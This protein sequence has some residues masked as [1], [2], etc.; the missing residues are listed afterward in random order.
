V[1][2]SRGRPT[3]CTAEL[4]EQI[5][6]IVRAG[7]YL[8][9]ACAL[10]G[11]VYVTAQS[12]LERGATETERRAAGLTA[13]Q[14]REHDLPSA[15]SQQPYV[16]FLGAITRARAEAESRH[17]RNVERIAMGGQVTELREEVAPDGTKVTT[18]KVSIGDWRASMAYLERVNTQRWG[19][20]QTVEVTGADGGP[21]QVDA[22]A[23]ARLAARLEGFMR[24]VR[25]DPNVIEGQVVRRAIASGPDGSVVFDESDDAGEQ[26]E[27]GVGGEPDGAAV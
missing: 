15:A 14:R 25:E 22:T 8:T 6:D 24:Q 17:V 3:R 18:K 11:T 23:G 13:A 27:G 26:P 19:R 21:V 20:R 9:T 16:D 7:D 10:T 12:W 2:T 4:T 1:P 5:A